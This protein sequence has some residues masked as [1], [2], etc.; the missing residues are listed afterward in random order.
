MEEF[1]FTFASGCDDAEE[2]RG[3]VSLHVLR[4]K[5]A[6]GQPGGCRKRADISEASPR[7]WACMCARLD[8]WVA[9]CLVDDDP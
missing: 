7:M 9:R 1:N 5:W 3:D 6:Y 8:I 4:N 2:N